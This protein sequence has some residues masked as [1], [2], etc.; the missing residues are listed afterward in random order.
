MEL[1]KNPE[2][3]TM[4]LDYFKPKRGLYDNINARKEAG[5]SRPKD[6]STIDPKIYRQM[7]QKRGGFAG[8]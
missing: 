1:L 5:K 3:H 4:S 6:K 2:E 7:K 8:K